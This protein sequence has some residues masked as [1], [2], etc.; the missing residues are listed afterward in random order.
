VVRE[1]HAW[2]HL[3]QCRQVL[4]VDRRAIAVEQ[5][6]VRERVAPG[7]QGAERLALRRQS[8]ERRDERRQTASRTLTPPQTN[9]RSS[10]PAWLSCSVGVS[11][12]PLLAATGRPSRLTMRQS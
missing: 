8:L 3:A 4:P 10:G 7:A 12:S 2:K 5:T 1:Q 6:G 9:R 11:M